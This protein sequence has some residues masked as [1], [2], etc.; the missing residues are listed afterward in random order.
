MDNL[1]YVDPLFHMEVILELSKLS[2]HFRRP[3][4]ACRFYINVVVIIER[5]RTSNPF[6]NDS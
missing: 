5:D 2:V 4:K 3:D 1:W 6:S